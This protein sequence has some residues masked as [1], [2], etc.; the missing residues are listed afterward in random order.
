MKKSFC[1]LLALL[2]LGTMTA[3]TAPPAS[4]SPTD[5]VPRGSGLYD[6]LSVLAQDHLLPAGAP[7]VQDLLGVTGRLYTRREMAYWFGS[8]QARST[9]LPSAPGSGLITD[10]QTLPQMLQYQPRV[11]VRSSSNLRDQAALDF[12][13]NVLAPE[14]GKQSGSA[15][16]TEIGA[17][18]FAQAETGGRSETSSSLHTHGDL[19]GRGRIFGTLGRDGA[20]TASATNIY[21]L[22]RDHASFTTRASGTGGADNPTA[23]DGIDEAYV[24]G[25]GGHGLRVTAGLL[26]QRWGDGYRGDLLVN[27][28]SPARPTLEAEIP[29]S[30]GHLLGSYRF[31]Q[32]EQTYRNSGRTVYEGGRRLEHPLGDRVTLSLEEAYSS[33]QFTRPIVLVLP[34][35]AFQQHNY[36]SDVEPNFFNYLANIGLSV[37]PNGPQGNARVYG[38]FLLDDLKAPKGINQGNSTPRK[39]GYLLGY[40]QVFPRS[41]TDAAIEYAHTDRAVYSDQ[42]RELAWF[43]DD[44]PQGHPIGPNGNELFLRLGQ[45]SDAASGRVSGSARPPP[46]L[47]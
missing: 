38:Q 40:A 26:R 19:Y 20:F 15:A 41:G 8:I 1:T 46:R 28:N 11:L 31:T 10:P 37:R 24:T 18:G 39:I 16:G 29:F 4:A 21:D 22:T 25:L 27:D 2:L 17:T 7:T 35:Y 45:R 14:L 6:A 32:Y 42:E 30:L 23:L 36:A 5:I 9:P 3:G 47:R 43:D 12:A 13:R 34:F 44:L 33:N